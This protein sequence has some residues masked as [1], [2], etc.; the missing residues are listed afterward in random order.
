MTWRASFRLGVLSGPIDKRLVVG[1]LEE[2]L[3]LMQG[4]FGYPQC[5][6]EAVVPSAGRAFP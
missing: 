6:R 2:L 1:A 5:S 3:F 4:D